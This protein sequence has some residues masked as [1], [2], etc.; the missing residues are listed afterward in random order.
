KIKYIKCQTYTQTAAAIKNM[1]VR[2]AP[3]IGVTAAYG[4]ALAVRQTQKFAPHA[5]K[6]F[7]KKAAMHLISARPT[8]VNLAWAVEKMSALINKTGFDNYEKLYKTCERECNFLYNDDIKTN[9]LMGAHGAKLLKKNSVVLTHCNAGALATVDY[10]TALGVIRAAHKDK[11]IKM[12]YAD[13]TRPYLQGARL[14]AFELAAENIPHRLICD[15]MAAYIM[16]TE[17]VSAVIVG[18]DRIAS[19]GD[20]ANKIGTYGLSI[21][22]KYHKIPFYIAAPKSTIDFKIKT[23]KEIII[24][25]RASDEVCKIFGKRIAPARTV[26]RHPGFDI[27]PYQNIT[28]II[29]EKGVFKPKDI[30][31]LK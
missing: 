1:I 7:I 17:H 26:A 29:T 3:A 6:A 16:Q 8:A 27:T 24:E 23:G 21:L 19:N 25:E 30:I 4:M 31:K 14:T 5:R 12:V 20:T 15:N 10:G 2:G 22:A 9:K 28:A 11:K 18:A 13:E